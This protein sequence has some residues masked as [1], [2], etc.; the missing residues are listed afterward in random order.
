MTDIFLLTKPPGASR[1][2]LC[3][4]LMEYSQ[5]VDLWLAGDGVYHL[6]NLSDLP[7]QVEKIE[8]CREDILARGLEPVE[9]VAEPDFF[10]RFVK[11]MME[12]SEKVYVF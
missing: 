2:N 5:N 10:D 8:A 3:F 12:N 11:A 1:S 9:G 6:L 4:R 7:V